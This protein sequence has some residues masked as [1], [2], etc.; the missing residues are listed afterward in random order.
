MNIYMV[1]EQIR[2]GK[3]HADAV[4]AMAHTGRLSTPAFERDLEDALQQEFG[5]DQEDQT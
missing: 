2:I 1:E 3:A 5:A 4:R